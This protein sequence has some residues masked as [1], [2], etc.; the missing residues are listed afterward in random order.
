MPHEEVLAEEGRRVVMLGNVAIARGALEAGIGYAAG[1]PGT[2]SSE[3]IEALS[4]ASRK[5]GGPIVEWSVNE[6]V[7][8]ESAYGASLSGVP[9]MATMKHVGVNVAADPLF[10]LAYTGTPSSIVVVS[11]DDPG[12]WSSQN[13]QD[14]RWYGVHAYIPVVEPSGVQD[15]KEATIEAFRISS[16][17]GHPVI[18]RTTTRVSHTRGVVEAGRIDAE[19]LRPRGRF[20]RNLERYTLIPAHAR[21]LREDLLERWDRI[22][23]RLSRSSLNKIEGGGELLLL[24]V[25]L[26]YRYAAEAARLLGVEA[27]IAKLQT[28]IPLP[29]SFLHKAL[30]GVSKVLVFEE[31]DPVVETLLKS[32]IHDEGL[33]VEVHGRSDG[34]LPRAGELGLDKAMRAIGALAGVD[35]GLPSP[36]ELGLD[37]PPRPPALC[38][39][40][41]YR[42]VFPGL[43]KAVRRSRVEPVYSGDI[44]CYS[45]GVLPPFRVQDT[46]VEMG[47]SIGLANGIAK[48]ANGQIPVAI[49]G[50][51]TFFHSGIT[52][53]V[54]AVHNRNPMLVI[55]LDNRTTAM[56]G[57]QPHPG[58]DVGAMGEEA[59]GVDIE[60]L[61]KA[62]GVEHVRVV[63]AFSIRG[64]E[65][66]VTEA[67]D[68]VRRERRPAVLI[69]KGSCILVALSQARRLGIKPPVYRVNPD[70][71]RACTVCYTAFNCPAIFRVEDGKA[72][73]NPVLCTGCGVCVDICP[74]DAFEPVEEPGK[75]WILLMRTATPAGW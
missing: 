15:A 40:C 62:I 42:G 23:E 38:P 45:L 34:Y 8:L 56:T 27:R 73:I 6:K 48:T 9:S 29:S 3:I 35:P 67:L 63:D 26:G 32:F 66:A 21:R 22:E 20:T 39:G 2:P 12:M 75:D 55:I 53:L 4:V 36:R 60:A 57:H 33:D 30:D 59:V 5:L 50:D 10:S 44:G 11:A 49:I 74:F 65:K 69:A 13:E 1:Y 43:R 52:G 47:G 41:P 14:N 31:G 71:C 72:K 46:I 37:L 28:P 25:G 61:V 70:K 17:Y 18:L 54:N 16:E 58:I 51:S 7:A 24:G 64:V 68:Y 19:K